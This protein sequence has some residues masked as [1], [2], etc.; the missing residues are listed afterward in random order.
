ML[1]VGGMAVEDVAW[2]THVYRRA[3]AE[4]IGTRLNLWNEP[5]LK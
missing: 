2:G 1:S 4:G 3:L 5:A